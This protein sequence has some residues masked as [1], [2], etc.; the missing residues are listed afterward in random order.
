MKKII[1]LVYFILIF[2]CSKQNA[3]LNEKALVEDSFTVK[4]YSTKSLVKEKFLEF[5]DLRLLLEEN[6]QF[7]ENIKSRLM[8]FKL[9]SS[10]VLKITP[11]SKIKKLI[12]T[13]LLLPKK[14]SDS[15]L[16]V[17]F[18]ISENNILKKDSIIAYIN[19]NKIMINE[20]VVITR[21]IKFKKFNP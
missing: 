17:L 9:D 2:S 7:K 1:F 15:L 8:S 12:I 14:N 10:E 4:K 19:D 20:E 21:K 18:E 5:Y 16:K 13:E 11:N 3:P 6:P